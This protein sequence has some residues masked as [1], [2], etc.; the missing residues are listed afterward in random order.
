MDSSREKVSMEVTA[1]SI[2][3]TPIALIETK[4]PKGVKY[5]VQYEDGVTVHQHQQSIV[6]DRFCWDLFQFA[7]NTPIVSKCSSISIIGKGYYNSNVPVKLLETIANHIFEVNGIRR[8]QD[9]EKFLKESF[10]VINNIFNQIVHRKGNYVATID[11]V[12]FINVINDPAIVKAHE[13]LQPTP[14]SVE[15]TYRAIRNYMNVKNGRNRFVEAYRSKAIND[16]QANQCIGPRGF[17]TGL[18]RTVYRKPITSGFIRGMQTLYEIITESLTAAKSLNATDTHIR[19]SE[20]ASRRI[21]LLTMSFTQVDVNDCGSN[22]LL[23]VFVTEKYLPNLKGIWYKVFD[24]DELKM[25][26]GTET[27]LINRVIKIRNAFGCKSPNPHHVCTTCLGALS[28]NFKENSNV[29]YTMTSFLMEKLTQAILSTKHLTHSVKK[30]AIK[31]EGLVEKYFYPSEANDIYFNQDLD[32]SKLAIVLPAN[33]LNK[34]ADVLNLDHTNVA[35]NKVGELEVVGIRN[36]KNN[37]P[38]IESV[39]ISYKDRMSTI[40]RDLLKHI[41]TT[42]LEVDARGNYIV[43]MKGFDI[44]RPV[45]SNQMKET[46]IISFVNKIASIIENTKPS[47]L[48]LE[49]HF[50]MFVDTVLDQFPCNLSV[51]QS[52]IFA[53]TAYNPSAGNYRLARNTPHAHQEKSSTLFR[54]RSASQLL[55]YESQQSELL[56]HPTVAFS[57]EYRFDHPL[58]VL[59]APAQ[60]VN[61]TI[62]SNL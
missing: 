27:D 40:T 51:L 22:D 29:G 6:L 8:Y 57:T 9:K 32:L 62:A 55:V 21:Q 50:F 17:V 42:D 31:L 58:D 18:D 20:Y 38:I 60:V 33:K 34:L 48:T 19:T 53:T 1:R 41:K 11:A 12:D 39:N 37:P 14:E 46:N 36:E 23:D 56:K 30:S 2:L 25:I 4:F 52:I 54:H 59:F 5:S 45:F 15:Q 49:E 7:P 43:P 44:T 26:N 16:N 35:L 61:S 28:E 47:R 10:N 24:T 13:S 3:E